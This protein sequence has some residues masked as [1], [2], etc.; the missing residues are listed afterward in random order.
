MRALAIAFIVLLGA[1]P[2][3]TAVLI[4]MDEQK[5]LKP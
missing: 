3:V 5:D 4:A 1:I 2:I